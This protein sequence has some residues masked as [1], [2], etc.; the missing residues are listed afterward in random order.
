MPT[1]AP[2]Q[3]ICDEISKE[4]S[5]D[6]SLRLPDDKQ[7][8]GL[9]Y[10]PI[11]WEGNHYCDIGL[12]QDGQP[13]I[14]TSLLEYCFKK[15]LETAL[16]H[17]KI[18]RKSKALEYVATGQ[19]LTKILTYII[20]TAEQL[21][22]G[23]LGSILILDDDGKRLLTGAAPNLPSDYS[24]AVHGVE[25]GPSIGSCGT[26]AFSK[27][28]VIV[29][30]INTHPYWENFK[31]L[32]LGFGLEACWSQ[33]IFSSKGK[34]L[35]TFAMYYNTPR[36]PTED[37]LNFIN[38]TASLAGIAIE[39]RKFE[40][41]LSNHR[42]HLQ[43]LVDARTI[44]LIDAKEVAEKANKAKS[45]FLSNMSHEL[46]TPM[47][48]ILGFAQLLSSSKK[49]PLPERQQ[50]YCNQIIKGGEH[51]LTLINEVLDLAKVEA[52][53]LS[54]AVEP[55]SIEPL[56]DECLTYAQSLATKKHIMIENR[57]TGAF[58]N[59]I[60]DRIR[61]K[62]VILNLISNATKYNYDNGLV[63]ID[64][65]QPTAET[66]R[67]L[68]GDTGFG[69]AQKDQIQ[70]FQ[71]FQR[72]AAENT[73]IEGT[74][75]GLMLTKKIVENM[76]AVIGYRSEERKGSEFWVDFKVAT[77]NQNDRNQKADSFNA[78]DQSKFK[79]ATVLYIEDNPANIELM[80]SVINRFSSL[81][82]VSA[83]TA[84]IGIRL[85]EEQQPDVILMDINLP[86]IDGFDA[87]KIL[88]ENKSTSHI[89]ILALSADAMP[90]SIKRAKKLGFHSYITKPIV[91]PEIL[92]ELENLLSKIDTTGKNLG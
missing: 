58:P 78:T 79:E 17:Q 57:L 30:D 5:C 49:F 19:E 16:S 36:R 87:F 59:I 76:G 29:E 45:I 48:A 37:E 7:Q 80:E 9:L 22:P 53:R 20:I 92:K 88:Y 18:K 64:V 13:Q 91:I 27:E 60:A 31:D 41:E 50:T 47:N 43:H 51:L 69:I 65:S 68:I 62:Q 86:G 66:V 33:P 4:F 46:R 67:V 28:R 40:T 83:H 81:T 89:P 85:A 74:G 63:W 1:F 54:L 61:A 2:L 8:D 42:D 82:M 70:L 12:A 35:G 38:E 6:L 77:S 73:E 25:I 71:P 11:I 24:Q 56:L 34:V 44:E 75:I 15:S 90:E 26:A 84:E 52:G 55:V 3:T 10:I 39:R 21:H 23:M 14:E 72:L 32:A